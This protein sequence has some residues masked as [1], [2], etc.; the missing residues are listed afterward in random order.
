MFAVDAWDLTQNKPRVLN[1]EDITNGTKFTDKGARTDNSGHNVLVH[2][3]G[4]IS[5]YLVE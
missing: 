5:A 3:D 2:V 4:V 1:P